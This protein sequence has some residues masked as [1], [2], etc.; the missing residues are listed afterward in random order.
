MRRIF[1]LLLL[2][3]GNGWAKRLVAELT[4]SHRRPGYEAIRVAL[5]LSL[6]RSFASIVNPNNSKDFDNMDANHDG[7][8]S[9]TEYIR[10]SPGSTEQ[11]RARLAMLFSQADVDDDGCLSLP[12][13]DFL[14][15]IEVYA[16]T[17][18]EARTAA[19][20]DALPSGFDE[21]VGRAVSQLRETVVGGK[22]RLE[23]VAEAFAPLMPVV[24][25]GPLEAGTVVLNLFG[26]A[27]IIRDGALNLNELD[28]FH[29][30]ARDI[31]AGVALHRLEPVRVHVD[32]DMLPLVEHMF[33]A[34]DR[35]KNGQ[36]DLDELADHLAA[37]LHP[38]DDRELFRKVV[39]KAFAKTDIDRDG[40]LSRE[41]LPAFIK[42]ISS[43]QPF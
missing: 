13:Y 5:L 22:A 30:V 19:F 35:N 14:K 41:E 42:L 15:Y 9:Y 17:T 32:A 23:D 18:F 21:Q 2:V 39:A 36:L 43:L 10:S 29:F 26:Q 24:G 38:G 31:L 33:P 6:A 7:L 8:V 34:C 40:G 12:E 27:D 4:A 25:L 37:H 1:L 11:D 16:E 28:Y 3:A 20:V